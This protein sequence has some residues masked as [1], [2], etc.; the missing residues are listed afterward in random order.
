MGIDYLFAID[1][2]KMEVI[3]S[4]S[5]KG[6]NKIK[7]NERVRKDDNEIFFNAVVTLNSITKSPDFDS[8]TFDLMD[9]VCQVIYKK[10]KQSKTKL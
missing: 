9:K 10:H 8:K 1:F 4:E 3:I 5:S 6:T 7:F 2:D